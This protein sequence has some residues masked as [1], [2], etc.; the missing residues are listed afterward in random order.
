MYKVTKVTY[1][2]LGF[3]LIFEALM[4]VFLVMKLSL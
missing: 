3:E 4:M 1:K 2:F